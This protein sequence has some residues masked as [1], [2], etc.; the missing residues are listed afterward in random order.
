MTKENE[1]KPSFKSD[2]KNQK[3]WRV[4]TCCLSRCVATPSCQVTDNLYPKKISR[5]GLR[6]HII[7][8]HPQCF[9][10]I[11]EVSTLILITQAG[12]LQGLVKEQEYP[13]LF[14]KNSEILGIDWN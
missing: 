12:L 10:S 9:N 3:L 13:D 11:K 14:K 2:K 4:C 1:K 8:K 5:T 7:L 6:D